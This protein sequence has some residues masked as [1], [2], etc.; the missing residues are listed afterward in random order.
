MTQNPEGSASNGMPRG[1]GWAP[2]GS[3]RRMLL[4]A[5]VGP[6]LGLVLLV[7]GIL[8]LNSGGKKGTVLVIIGGILILFWIIIL[9][10]ARARKKI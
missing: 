4:M 6:L 8:E 9:P 2:W 5:I 7:A 1:G 10:V 3:R